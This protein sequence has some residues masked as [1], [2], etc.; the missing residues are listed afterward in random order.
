MNGSDSAV[1]RQG[2]AAALAEGVVSANEPALLAA[3]WPWAER[4][5]CQL[6][7]L[8]H[9]ATARCEVDAKVQF[10]LERRGQRPLL[11]GGSDAVCKDCCIAALE[12]HGCPWWGLCWRDY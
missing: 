2:P 6:C 8:R 3:A 7:R 4:R 12:G 11:I 1:G 5:R 9:E 10:V